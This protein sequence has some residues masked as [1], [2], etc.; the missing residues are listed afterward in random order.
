MSRQSCSILL[1]SE[2]CSLLTQLGGS[3]QFAFTK[4]TPNSS[5]R[6]HH[7]EPKHRSISLLRSSS[8]CS[9]TMKGRTPSREV[10]SHP[11]GEEATD[12]S[13]PSPQPYERLLLAD[14]QK[15]VDIEKPHHHDVL[16]GRGYV[17]MY[18]FRIIL[19]CRFFSS[20]HPPCFFKMFYIEIDLQ[21]AG[22]T[23]MVENLSDCFPQGKKSNI[24]FISKFLCCITCFS[25]IFCHRH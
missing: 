16:C 23:S 7:K 13:A 5:Y 20:G 25:S 12:Q 11:K 15:M 21:V 2:R 8:P 9:C 3:S 4:T 6:R 24:L 19:R 10:K 14:E 17:L 22:Q 1:C 18:S